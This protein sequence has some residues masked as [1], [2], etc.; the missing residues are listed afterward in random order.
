MEDSIW[1]A[2][3]ASFRERVT[4][5]EPAP[6]GVSASAVTATFALGL[7]TKVLKISS[8]RKNFP[9]DPQQV[10]ALL[11]SAGRESAALARAADQDIAAFYRYLDCL[12]LPRATEK[13]QAERRQAMD[14]AMHEAIELP[15]NAARAAARGLDLCMKA[16]GLVHS[17]VAADLGAAATLLAGAVQA[18]LLSVDFNVRQLDSG[19]AL[20]AQVPAE[21]LQL[22]NQ[23]LQ[24][25]EVIRKR[26]LEIIGGR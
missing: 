2:T 1:T 19:E 26:V 5:Q 15:L 20:R 11:D 8:Q 12:R 17:F 10:A 24:H 14:A 4:G 21:S 6:A 23:A 9:G 25:A 18:I 7:L 16:T 22:E 3:L 13:Q